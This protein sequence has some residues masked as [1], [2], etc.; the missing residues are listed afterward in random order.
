MIFGGRD[1]PWNV[2]TKVL[3]VCK[4]IFIPKI[5]N[6]KIRCRVGIAHQK[7]QKSQTIPV[8]D[9]CKLPELTALPGV[10]RYRNP[11][12]NPLPASDEGAKMYLIRAKT[13]V[14]SI[15][16][17]FQ[18]KSLSICS[19]RIR[20]SNCFKR[21]NPLNKKVSSFMSICLN[22]FNSCSAPS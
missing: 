16:C 15:Y 4:I 7:N 6:A 20:Y 10:M 18:K 1:V 17:C 13:A 2:S 19:V 21:V 5:S 22:T 3:N 12:P 9:F 11:T 14:L 8:F